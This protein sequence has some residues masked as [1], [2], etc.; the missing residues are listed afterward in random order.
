MDDMQEYEVVVKA[1]SKPLYRYCYH[2][3]CGDRCLTE[4]TLNDVFAVVYQK[5][6]S[7]N[8]TN[9]RAYL[10]R[11]AD[12]C[13][14]HNRSMHQKY[15]I[16]NR[17]LEEISSTD[18]GDTLYCT[19]EYFLRDI[20]EDKAI[21]RIKVALPPEDFKLF[22]FRYIHKKTLMQIVTETGLPY[23]SVRL[24]LQRIE[25]AAKKEMAIIFT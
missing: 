25:E 5:W 23:S 6:D 13:I 18:S 11:V 20:D 2:K 1:Y 7:L 22:S 4:E 8:K 21:E 12:N 9:I 3:L 19:D 17:S 24:R 10:Y 16:H 14:K 15:Y